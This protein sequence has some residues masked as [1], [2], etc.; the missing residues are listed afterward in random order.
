VRLPY[1][2]VIE[3]LRPDGTLLGHSNPDPDWEPAIEWT[4]LSGLRTRGVWAPDAHAERS[5]VPLWHSDLGE[6]F[7]RGFQVS[8][9]DGDGRSWHEEFPIRYFFD[10]AREAAAE[11]IA[12]GRLAAGDRYLYR[13]LAY[14][15]D[16]RVASGDAAP[17]ATEEVGTALALHEPPPELRTDVAT[18][19]ADAE[20]GDFEVYIPGGVIA[21]ASALTTGA[22]EA[23]TGGILIGHVCRAP[24]ADRAAAQPEPATPPSSEICVSVTALIAARHTVSH[25]TRLTFTSDTWTDVRR[26]VALRRQGEMVLGWFHSHPVFAWCRERG[27]PIERQRECTAA[28][29]FFS[30]EDVAL[31]RTMFPRAFTVALLM[32]HSVSGMVPRLFG[33]RA[34]F[35]EP[36]G[37]T[38]TRHR[39]ED[40]TPRS[41]LG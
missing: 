21:E 18:R 38:L 11:L 13:V 19:H 33:W 39:L 16:G 7:L 12:S 2:L 10:L 27:C 5:I 32:S 22:G 41:P 36:R 6:P 3:V 31:H 8:L 37:Y 35:V 14:D 25:S 17:F 23:E 4:R 20:D 15:D 34:G 30:V 26:T 9:A 29:G 40:A 1:R 24:G 28:A